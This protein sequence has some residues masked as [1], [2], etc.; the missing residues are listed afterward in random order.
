T[1]TGFPSWLAELTG[2]TDWPAQWALAPFVSG[3]GIDLSDVPDIPIR[4][5][6][7]CPSSDA[8]AFD[9]TQ[10]AAS[11]DVSSCSG[12]AQTFDD[13]PASTTTNLINNLNTKATFFTL[14]Q[15]I[16]SYPDIYRATLAKGHLM[17][18]HT[19]S[20]PFLPSLTNEQIAGELQWSIWAMQAAGGHV[21]KWFRP[22]YGGIDNRVRAIV[23]KFG[24]RSVLWNYDT[25]DWKLAGGDITP[26]EIFS[27]A[28]SWIAQGPGV[29]LEHDIVA[30]NVEVGIELASSYFTDLVT[31]NECVG[32][33]EY[34]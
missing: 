29:V 31:V 11:D 2:R 6:G 15:N 28:T 14:G 30:Q 1:E 4:S 7:T 3:T 17:A 10:C 12:F 19:W 34:Q 9:C 32:D 27:Q 8:C 20:H 18:S 13:G 16:I 26:E 23:R 24:M 22:P 25:N 5:Q 21:P 33:S